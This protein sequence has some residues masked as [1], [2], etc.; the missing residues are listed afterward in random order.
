[1]KLHI[2]RISLFIS[3]VFLGFSC[4]ILKP[5][6]K[7]K[8]TDSGLKYKFVEKYNGRIAPDIGKLMSLRM[9]YG[10]EDTL[11]FNSNETP[12]KVMVLPMK[13]SAFPGDFYEMMEMMHLGDSVVFYL[14]AAS[15]F[16]KT[17]EYPHVPDFATEV[18]KL[19]FHVKIMKIQTE[20]EIEMEKEAKIIELKE[21]EA[22]IIANYLSENNIYTKPTESGLYVLIEKQGD[23]AKPNKGDKVRVH[24]S[25]FLLD[26]TKF[27]SS[28]DRD[29]PFEFPIGQGR[30]IKGWDEGIAMLNVGTKAKLIIPS[31]LA[32][33]ERG[34][35]NVIGPYSTL[36][37]EVE[38]LDII[39]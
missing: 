11:F 13:V 2:F 18:D 34:A 29:Q 25:G 15:F 37:F 7:F 17:A 4:S 35:G 27:D 12:A 20:E 21:G 1:M 9:T 30:V 23:G 6:S 31:D 36:I 39:K 3:I 33:R 10:T 19:L 5:G 8:T 14:D 38:L 28:V 26:G 16:T 24:Y 22:A 32:Y